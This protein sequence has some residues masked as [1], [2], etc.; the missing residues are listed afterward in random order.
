MTRRI[1]VAV[2]VGLALLLLAA[3]ALAQTGGG[4]DLSW[5]TV[6]GGGGASSGGFSLEGTIGQPDAGTLSGGGFTLQGGFWPAADSPPTATATSTPTA[7]ATPVPTSTPTP[8]AT[9]TPTR[10]STPSSTPSPTAAPNPCTSPTRVSVQAVPNGDGRLRVEVSVGAGN[11]LRRIEFRTEA[12]TVGNALVN[13][14]APGPG[15]DR[16]TPPPFSVT[17]L[18]P[19]S[20]YLFF[21]RRAGP[22]ATT[23]PFTVTDA[24]GAWPTFVGGGPGAF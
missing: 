13:A 8:T 22:G 14:P 7:T 4:F 19:S 21:V 9:S 6:D 12:N 16:D 11:E 2:S 18:A 3:G 10:T 15:L 24:C 5:S 1:G 17:G 20:T 23:L